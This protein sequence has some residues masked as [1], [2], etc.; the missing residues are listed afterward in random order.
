M[1][2]L[3]FMII[4][5]ARHGKDTVA[6]MFRVHGGFN[7]KSS[8]LMCCEIFIYRTLKEKYGYENILECFEDRQ[9][10]RAEWHDLITDFN[11]PDRT[12]LS[13]EIFSRAPIYVGIRHPEE[14]M[15]AREAGLFDLGVWVDASKRLP[16]ED[17]SSNKMYPELADIIIDNNGTVAETQNR[18]VR[19]L[20]TFK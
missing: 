8:S 9:N 2:N 6:E 10:H 4:G 7:F 14:Y 11:I 12:R 3:K 18:V 15:A 19:L 16:P 20:R 1:S 13:R 5:H 17:S